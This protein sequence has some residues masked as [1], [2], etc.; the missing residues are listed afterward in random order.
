MLILVLALFVIV[1]S[2]VFAQ[3]T[4]DLESSVAPD[5]EPTDD[6]T[7][8]YDIMPQDGLTLIDNGNGTADI[9][10]HSSNLEIGTYL[11]WVQVSDET[12]SEREPFAVYVQ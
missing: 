9:T 6:T 11:F 1:P 7:S 2:I 4:G 12:D 5:I 8:P 3:N 10:I